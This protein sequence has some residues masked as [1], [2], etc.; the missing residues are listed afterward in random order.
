MLTERVRRTDRC[1]CCDALVIER[2]RD[3]RGYEHLRCRTCGLLRIHPDALPKVEAVYT[4]AYF[5]GTMHRQTN[6]RAG[7]SH[8]YADPSTSHRTR[9]Y[10]AY[11]REIV[12]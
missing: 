5:D 3:G 9:Q 12:R 2:S 4:P 10:D 8:T 1:Y 6:G 11:V 7:Y